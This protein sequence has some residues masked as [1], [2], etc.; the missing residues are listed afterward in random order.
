MFGRSPSVLRTA[1][2]PGHRAGRRSGEGAHD[3][4]TD[5]AWQNIADM[6]AI[7]IVDISEAVEINHEHRDHAPGRD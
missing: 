4:F 7:E 5:L 3:P 6:M 1:G 2:L